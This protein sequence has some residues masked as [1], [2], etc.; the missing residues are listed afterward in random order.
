MESKVREEINE[1]RSNKKRMIIW[2]I[3]FLIFLVQLY[4]EMNFGLRL[5]ILGFNSDFIRIGLV[6]TFIFIPLSFNWEGHNILKKLYKVGSI[7][8]SILIIFVSLFVFS[9]SRY[10]Y[11]DSPKKTNK[12]VVE[13]SSFLLYGGSTFYE[14][15]YGFFIRRIDNYIITDDGYRPFSDNEYNFKWLDENSAILEYNFR[16]DGSHD[17]EKIEL[18]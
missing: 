12:L 11:F 14:K 7:L 9:G 1:V 8:I 4:L 6:L 3:V 13:E 2:G 5:I 16:K 10:F 17:I 18:D 15:K